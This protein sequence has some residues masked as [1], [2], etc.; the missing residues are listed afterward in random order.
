MAT[1]GRRAQPAAGQILEALIAILDPVAAHHRLDGLGQ[2]LPDI[3]EIARKRAGIDLEPS[4]ALETAIAERDISPQIAAQIRQD[5]VE[6]SDDRQDF[7]EVIVGLAAEGF[8]FGPE[9][10]SLSVWMLERPVPL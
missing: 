1:T 3:V 2:E 7:S 8:S 9:S 4:E 6:T 10:S 5:G